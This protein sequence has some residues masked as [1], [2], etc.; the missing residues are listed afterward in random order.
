LRA[1]LGAVGVVPVERLARAEAPAQVIAV[2]GAARLGE[3]GVVRTV[4]PVRDGRIVIDPDRIDV[5][6][7]QSGS[8]GKRMSAPPFRT[9]AP[10]SVQS[11]A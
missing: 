1:T 8:R 5:G 7:A 10:Y 9:W 4:A 3:I 2:V 6:C 11:A